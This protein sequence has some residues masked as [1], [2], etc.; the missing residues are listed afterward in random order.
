MLTHGKVQQAAKS[1]ISTK[2]LE[3]QTWWNYQG[4]VFCTERNP[5]I[6]NN[7]DLNVKK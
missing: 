4:S 1:S 6:S 7:I 2:S 5:K 3:R